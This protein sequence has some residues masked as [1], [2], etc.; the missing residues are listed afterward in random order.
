MIIID[1]Y[2]SLCALVIFLIIDACIEL[3]RKP[4]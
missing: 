3:I 1:L 2:A 4:G